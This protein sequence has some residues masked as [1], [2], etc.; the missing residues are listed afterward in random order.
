MDELNDLMPLTPDH[1][2]E[3]L[4][5]LKQLFPDLFT[6]EGTLNP[7][8][9]AKLADPDYARESERYEF[10]WHGKSA[11]KR[12]AFTPSTA[13]LVCDP[14]RSVN[15]DQAGGN[16]II[17]GENLEVL[18]L[19]T[20]AYRERIKC[21]YIDP[22]YNTG[23]DFVYSDNYTKS[24]KSYWE[25][26]VTTEDG[27][28]VDSNSETSGRYHSD[29]LSMMHS[30]LLLANKLLKDDGI[31]L[32]SIDDHEF[33]NLKR[34]MDEVFGEENFVATVIWEKGRKND[35]KLFSA[36][37]EYIVVYARDK[38]VLR[39]RNI[40]WREPK[41][42]AQEIWDK[43][44][45]LKET[46]DSNYEAME[47]E[48]REWYQALPDN[49]LS[50]KLSRYRHIDKWGP[51]RDRDISWPGGGG[52]RY[53]VI[54]PETKQPCKV[55]ERGWGFSTSESMKQQIA[56]G[57]IVFRDDHTEPPFRKAHLKPI[58][59]ELLDAEELDE[60]P[61]DE[62]QDDNGNG[63]G[64]QVM[65][66]YIYKQSQAAAKLLRSLMGAKV[67]DNP[68]DHE[69]LARLIR[70][71]TGNDDEPAIILDFFAGSGSTGHAVLELNKDGKDR[72]RF[73]L[74]Q[75]PELV[76][77]KKEAGKNALKMGLKKVSDV[78][79]E[80]VKRVI[81]SAN[82]GGLP[83]TD[84]A[85]F[86]VYHLATSSFP[87][88]E[89]AP[90]PDKSPEENV[91]LLREYIRDKE[92]AFHIAFERDK[93]IDEVLLKNGFMLDYTL[94][95]QEQFTINTVFLAQDAYRE[96]LICLDVPLDMATVD[97]FKTHKE[98]RLICLEQAL[99]TTR[100][101]NLKHNLGDKLVA[102]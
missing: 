50:R 41:P 97:Y 89:F 83:F 61:E 56:L 53:D 64:M 40:I 80:R 71:V 8:E 60:M 99:D 29:W 100:K 33:T 73:I 62:E 81:T 23:K 70:Y 77:S 27:V 24:R 59:D 52:P 76:N 72:Y 17:E 1:N 79:I 21:I 20:C 28:K 49:H 5:T 31:I 4:E 74:V 10:R 22:P 96:A 12:F 95:R 48:L 13:A 54:H 47:A 25:E 35:A 92:T 51:W 63:V 18:K 93:I 11:S 55:P 57:L 15:P 68:K 67:F 38:A 42:G 9:V 6:N 46:H 2:R 94:T 19:L 90:D 85:G 101:W 45:K 69:V 91:A 34:L 66:T 36:G 78:T 86:K 82:D 7:E 3:R 65:P 75:L 98:Q 102:F 14:A 30:R 32:V 84:E 88:V 37:H 87:R 39:E 58:S 16:M 26:S 44:L 43:Y